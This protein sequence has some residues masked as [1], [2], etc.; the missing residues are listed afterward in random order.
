MKKILN[1]GLVGYGTVG[2]GVVKILE[3]NNAI[4]LRKAGVKINVKSI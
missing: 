1:I 2:K 3:K 4:A